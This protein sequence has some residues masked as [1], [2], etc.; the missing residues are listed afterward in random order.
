MTDVGDQAAAC[1]ADSA[2]QIEERRRVNEFNREC[3]RTL[4]DLEKS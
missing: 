1:G 2:T 3:V 4:K